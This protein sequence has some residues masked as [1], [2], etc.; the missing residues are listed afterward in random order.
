LFAELTGHDTRQWDE[1]CDTATAGRLEVA[2]TAADGTTYTGD[3]PGGDALHLAEP[4]RTD[5]RGPA[6]ARVR[7]ASLKT[8]QGTA[9]GQGRGGAV[10]L[11]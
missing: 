1:A 6:P 2:M 7:A 10:W 3:E 5:V 8:M 11:A 9:T 4:D